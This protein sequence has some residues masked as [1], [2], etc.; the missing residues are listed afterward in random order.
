MARVGAE[1]NVNQRWNELEKFYAEKHRAYHT[2][3]HVVECLKEF[4]QVKHLVKNAD[5]MEM[6][7]FYHD[8][9]YAPEAKNNEEQSAKLLMAVAK[10]FR[11]DKKFSQASAR[12]V[13]STKIGAELKTFEEKLL[14]DMDYSVLGQKWEVF[15]K[16]NQ[17]IRKENAHYSPSDYK[18]E[19]TAFLKSLL[20]KP[21]IFLTNVFQ[22]K[23]EYTAISNV[24]K[25][26]KKLG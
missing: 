10:D 5:A 7:V 21:A 14:H 16:Y 18:K 4:D 25:A 15:Q 2:M 23:Y 19:R 12:L 13:R 17:G 11:L 22:D 24:K 9:V 20:E 8:A 6:A 26:L 1:G 3:N